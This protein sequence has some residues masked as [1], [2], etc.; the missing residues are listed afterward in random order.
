MATFSISLSVE[1]EAE[2]Y[3][4]AFEIQA[5]LFDKIGKMVEVTGGPYEIDAEQVDGF[6]DE[7]DDSEE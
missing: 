6:E 2:N 7:V 1:V 4:E 3:Q 5:K